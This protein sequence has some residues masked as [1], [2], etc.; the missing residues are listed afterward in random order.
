MNGADPLGLG[1]GTLE[2]RRE[3][4]ECRVGV[5]GRRADG[6][7]QRCQHEFNRVVCDGQPD[8]GG[9][10]GV[11]EFNL[12][13]TDG[14]NLASVGGRIDEFDHGGCDRFAGSRNQR[15]VFLLDHW[16]GGVEFVGVWVSC[17]RDVDVKQRRESGGLGVK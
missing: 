8:G 16:V 10:G 5:C 9:D 2:Q 7:D 17:V 12:G 15:V 11:D 3:C 1:R 4:V 6:S 14:F 13:R